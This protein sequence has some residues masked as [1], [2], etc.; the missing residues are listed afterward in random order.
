MT[1]KYFLDLPPNTSRNFCRRLA[2][3]SPWKIKQ[4]EDALKEVNPLLNDSKEWRLNAADFERVYRIVSGTRIRANHVPAY[5]CEGY[6]KGLGLCSHQ[7]LN[8]GK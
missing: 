1:Q 4:W 6:Q 2:W 3:C 5:Y 7:C 8:C